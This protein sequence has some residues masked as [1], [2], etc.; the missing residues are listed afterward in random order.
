MFKK[1]LV[2]CAFVALSSSDCLAYNSGHQ[3]LGK[4][5]DFYD[6]FTIATAG[7]YTE[8]FS[9]TSLTNFGSAQ[10]LGYYLGDA[11]WNNILDSKSVSYTAS[12]KNGGSIDSTV[13]LAAGTYNLDIST[14]AMLSAKGASYNLQFAAVPGPIAGAGLPVFAL[15]AAMLFYRRR[16]V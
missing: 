16:D 13:Y 4:G 2:A 10:S 1:A 3:D 7:L 5:S 6:T 9:W 11:T 14:S 15:L 8:I 12:A